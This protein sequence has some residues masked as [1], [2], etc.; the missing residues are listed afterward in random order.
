SGKQK[1]GLRLDSRAAMMRGN[2]AGPV[3]L[4]GDPAESR[5]IQA[6]RYEGETQM[7]PKGKLTDLEIGALTQWV[8]TG[9]VGREPT[10]DTRPPPA[11][12]ADGRTSSEARAYWAFQPLQESPPPAVRDALWP[13]SSLDRFILARLEEK[14]L[15]PVAPADKRTLIRRATFD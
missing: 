1:A 15:R 14:G 3:L 5:L 12:K 8:K 10:S 2:E 9:A 6:I 4:P 7:P 11:R 13:I